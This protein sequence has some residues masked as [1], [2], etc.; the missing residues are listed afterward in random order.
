MWKIWPHARLQ[1]FPSSS[2]IAYSMQ[3]R[4]GNNLSC[5]WYQRLLWETVGWE[6]SLNKRMSW[7]SFLV[8]SVQML[9]LW[10]F[11]KRQTY[12]SLFR[13]KN[14]CALL[15]R[16]FSPLQLRTYNFIPFSNFLP[17]C[18]CPWVVSKVSHNFSNPLDGRSIF[19]SA[20]TTTAF[21]ANLC[22]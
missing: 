3:N 19:S 8:A 5:E 1:T 9:Q 18:C 20:S 21:L 12:F 2:F 10:T 11:M 22:G 16:Y 6:V 13:I 7:K 17:M 4:K 14:K 15:I